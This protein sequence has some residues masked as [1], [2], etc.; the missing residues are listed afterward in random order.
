[1]TVREKLRADISRYGYAL[2][3]W[4]EMAG[5]CMRNPGFLATTLLRVQEAA[6]QRGHERTASILRFMALALTGC[7]LVPGCRVGKG[8]L[9]NHPVGI[10]IGRGSVVGDQCTLLQNVTLGERFADGRQPHGYPH[11]GHH[12][13]IG[14][15][16]SV[17]GSVRVGDNA[18]IGANSVVL[19][20]VPAGSLAVGSPARI[21]PGLDE[22]E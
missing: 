7:D 1:M 16:A 13:T 22:Q 12:V 6:L 17:L 11:I 19:C 9:M 10:V 8:L 2:P 18:V 15:G 4:R 21:L 3:G 5:A 14:A 20:D